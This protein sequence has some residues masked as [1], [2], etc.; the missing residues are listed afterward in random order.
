MVG[1]RWKAEIIDLHALDTLGAVSGEMRQRLK[2]ATTPEQRRKY[3][4]LL[5]HLNHHL[6]ETPALMKMATR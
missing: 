5:T 2:R 3:K 1:I 6:L 4:K